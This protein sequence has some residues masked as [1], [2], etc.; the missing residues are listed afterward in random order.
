MLKNVWLCEKA[1]MT[2]P[3][4]KFKIILWGVEDYLFDIVEFLL[5]NRDFK[6]KKFDNSVLMNLS[7]E[8]SYIVA[9]FSTSGLIFSIISLYLLK[10]SN[11][12]LNA[13]IRTC[14]E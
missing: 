9:S 11:L 6:L 7:T 14:T 13:F 4:G 1:A 2:D 5:E 10:M 8:H 12:C 3:L